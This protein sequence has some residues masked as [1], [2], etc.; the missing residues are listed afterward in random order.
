LG[1]EWDPQFN[2]HI[3]YISLDK[4]TVLQ[5]FMRREN[6]ESES[7]SSED[8]DHDFSNSSII[9]SGEILNP[10]DQQIALGR[11]L[12]HRFK[13]MITNDPLLSAFVG[14]E[15]ANTYLIRQERSNQI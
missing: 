2:G 15:L 5:K 6:I 8:I 10:T 1:R 13:E 11:S 12:K 4:L 3:A 7:F 9:L 14:Q